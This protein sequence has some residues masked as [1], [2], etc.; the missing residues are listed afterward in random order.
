M[1]FDVEPS[2]SK[3]VAQLDQL[4][5]WFCHQ[6]CWHHWFQPKL[7][8]KTY[9][10]SLRCSIMQEVRWQQ[11]DWAEGASLQWSEP[12]AWGYACCC[13]RLELGGGEVFSLNSLQIF[14]AI[15]FRGTWSPSWILRTRKK[16]FDCR[17]MGW[18][19]GKGRYDDR[20]TR[21]LYD[22][23]SALASLVF[24]SVCTCCKH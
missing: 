14:F 7:G 6:H 18:L 23:W 4:V 22:S 10:R 24:S 19:A 13:W 1:I 17:K 12:A 2:W 3:L 20:Q 5:Q 16:P 11:S 8:E 21:L 15:P 9:C